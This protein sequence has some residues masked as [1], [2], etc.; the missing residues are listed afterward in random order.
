MK[1]LE[2]GVMVSDTVSGTKGMLTHL[3]VDMD[4][5]IQYIYQPR[6]LSPK[7]GQPIDTLLL[8]P[9]RIKGAKEIEVDLPVEILGTQAEDIATGFKGTVINLIYHING[10]THA[11]I[12]PKGIIAAT[13]NTIAV[14]EFDVRRI[15]GE[16]IKPLKAKDL[17]KSITEKPSPVAT[18]H[19]S[20]G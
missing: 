17:K 12:K 15:K 16:A 13:G 19:V 14:H 18:Q 8:A 2:L 3:V 5:I 1:V 4:N 11:G 7:T 10:C 6:G 9:S 20:R